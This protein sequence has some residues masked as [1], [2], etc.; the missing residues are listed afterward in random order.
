MVEAGDRRER[1]KGPSLRKGMGRELGSGRRSADQICGIF[2]EKE[3]G[4]VKMG[5][6]DDGGGWSGGGFFGAIEMVNRVCVW[7]VFFVDLCG[8]LVLYF[9]F[10]V[11]VSIS[12]VFSCLDLVMDFV[13]ATF[14]GAVGDVGENGGLRMAWSLRHRKDPPV[15]HC[16]SYALYLWELFWQALSH[17]RHFHFRAVS[18]S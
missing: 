11:D 4:S 14:C 3:S 15:S 18:V 13:C 5:K 10:D 2:G 17:V 9:D 7:R 1:L 16:A 6:I 12:F 8:T